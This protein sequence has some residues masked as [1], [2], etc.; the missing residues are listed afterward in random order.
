MSE[1]EGV[2]PAGALPSSTRPRRGLGRGWWCHW[3]R[4]PCTEGPGAERDLSGGRGQVQGYN[5]KRKQEGEAEAAARGQ[6]RPA[7]RSGRC[8][9]WRA[10]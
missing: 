3:V 2:A 6:G 1:E 10:L 7:A 5:R 9:P 8:L 4:S